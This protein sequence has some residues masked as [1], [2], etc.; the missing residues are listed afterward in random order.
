MNGMTTTSVRRSKIKLIDLNA[1]AEASECL[2][3]LAHP[4]RLR[5]IQMLL[6]D[7]Y[8]VGQLAQACGIAS[9]MASGHLRLLQRCG[10]LNQERVGRE[11]FYHVARP[12]LGEIIN[13]LEE[14]FSRSK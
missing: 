2:K 3:T 9:P 4:H 7:R 6:H 11:V 1:L 10:L 12:C 13:G 8:T 14:H 5:M